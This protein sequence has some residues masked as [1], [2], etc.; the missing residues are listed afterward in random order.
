[1]GYYC[2]LPKVYVAPK[3]ADYFSVVIITIRTKGIRTMYVTQSLLLK[4]GFPFISSVLG[5]KGLSSG[6]LFILPLAYRKERNA[7]EV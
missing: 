7:K 2:R 6:M 5:S 4:K 3:V 1:M